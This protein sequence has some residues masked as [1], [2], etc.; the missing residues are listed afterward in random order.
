MAIKASPDKLSA[1]KSELEALGL[2]SE[3]IKRILGVI[4]RPVSGYNGMPPEARKFIRQQLCDES[5]TVLVWRMGSDTLIKV[6]NGR[7][8]NGNKSQKTFK[9]EPRRGKWKRSAAPEKTSAMRQHP[10]PK[11]QEEVA[12]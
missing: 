2:D 6:G 5:K 4:Q 11:V 12:A 9:F 7:L 1:V 8:R 3:R 10:F